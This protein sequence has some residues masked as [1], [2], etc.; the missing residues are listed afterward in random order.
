[1]SCVHV[2]LLAVLRPRLLLSHRIPKGDHEVEEDDRALD[3]R[4]YGHDLS[5]VVHRFGAVYGK[6]G[7][8]VSW[9][10]HLFRKTSVLAGLFFWDIRRHE[11]EVLG[12][13]RLKPGQ[14]G[15]VVLC[16]LTLRGWSG[17]R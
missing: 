11:A 4:W 2:L 3:H 1:M 5:E 13:T 8:W 7:T 10:W 12:H 6:S 9:R 15:R 16:N 14:S 17:V